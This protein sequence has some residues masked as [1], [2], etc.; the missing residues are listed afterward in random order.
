MSETKE[1]NVIDQQQNEQKNLQLISRTIGS[2][3]LFYFF[4][5]QQKRLYWSRIYILKVRLTSGL[6]A[7]HLSPKPFADKWPETNR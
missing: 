4:I 5:D 6:D 7:S 1:I 2:Y 3:S